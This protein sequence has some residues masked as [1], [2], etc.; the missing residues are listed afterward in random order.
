MCKDARRQTPPETTE[1]LALV[2]NLECLDHAR[3]IPDLRIGAAATSLEQRLGDIERR[4]QSSCSRTGETTGKSV[5]HG[6]VL[7]RRVQQFLGPLVG[8]KLDRSK[9][10]SHG[11]RRG[12][13]HV[14]GTQA[15]RLVQLTGALPDGA[16]VIALQ[17]HAL[18][19]H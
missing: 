17:L 4:R 3:R 18:L 8:G 6:G 19:D 9:R 14:E 12:V 5:R 10:N 11:Q 13:R 1:A 7:L 16:E 2:D 15:F